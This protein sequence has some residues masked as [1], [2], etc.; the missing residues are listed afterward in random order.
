MLSKARSPLL[1]PPEARR[2]PLAAGA[3]VLHVILGLGALGGGSAL[4][5]GPR[6]E[7]LPLPVSLLSGSPFETYWGP[8]LILFAFL[9]VFPILV[10]VLA[11][12]HHRWAPLLT[13]S[14]GTTLL[15]WMAVEIA[16]IGYAKN[17]PLQPIYIGLGITICA[18]GLAWLRQSGRDP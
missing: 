10:A 9:G 11:W 2:G 5:L 6:G 12:R 8:G 3:I 14:V 1:R 17:P 16:I 13:F 4:M 18:V 7:L 15:I